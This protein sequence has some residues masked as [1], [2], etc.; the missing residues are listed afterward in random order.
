MGGAEQD[1]GPPDPQLRRAA[2]T[3]PPRPTP[4]S[5]NRRSSEQGG[6]RQS[7]GLFSHCTRSRV[8]RCTRGCE[9]MCAHG[10][11]CAYMG[12]YTQVYG[13]TQTHVDREIHTDT[14][15]CGCT[16][17]HKHVPKYMH[18]HTDAEAHMD[19]HTHTRTPPCTHT[20][21]FPLPCTPTHEPLCWSSPHFHPMYPMR[22]H[23]GSWLRC[24][25]VGSS[26]NPCWA[27]PQSRPGHPDLTL[28]SAATHSPGD[29]AARVGCT[30]VVALL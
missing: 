25:I 17:V 6:C 14:Q 23:H 3:R 18:T 12:A 1:P 5:T 2:L 15:T 4:K 21:T 19:G 27:L 22:P 29:R 26:R 28:C 16:H 30:T 11:V 10:E 24:H 7:C 8:Y 20:H 13:H 9:R